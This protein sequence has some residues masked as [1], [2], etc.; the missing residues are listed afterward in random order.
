M[1][2]INNL[3]HK[4]GLTTGFQ[5]NS[6][7]Y[8]MKG[9]VVLRIEYFNDLVKIVGLVFKNGELIKDSVLDLDY[10]HNKTV[11]VLDKWLENKLGVISAYN[12]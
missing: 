1:D 3:L 2:K 10:V 6:S 9:D 4:Y 8:Y 11:D 5:N 12:I 7:F